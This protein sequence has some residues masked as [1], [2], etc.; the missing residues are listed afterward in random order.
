MGRVVWLISLT[1]FQCESSDGGFETGAFG[2]AFGGR[3]LIP[4]TE[5]QF[6]TKKR[7]S[8]PSTHP[9]RW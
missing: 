8:N 2:G 9:L 4:P 5:Q 6:K 1:L 7:L 3:P